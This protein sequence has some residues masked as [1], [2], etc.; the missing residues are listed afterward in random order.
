MLRS[1]CYL[2]L[3]L[4]VLHTMENGLR[5]QCH[6]NKENQLKDFNIKINKLK[7]KFSKCIIM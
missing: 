7:L 4:F 2:D 5:Y 6:Y 1:Y 3:V